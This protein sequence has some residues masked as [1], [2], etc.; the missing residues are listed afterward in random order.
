M[1]VVLG[2]LT[3]SSNVPNFPQKLHVECGVAALKY[4]VSAK[5]VVDAVA[6]C[7]SE[8]FL[9]FRDVAISNSPRVS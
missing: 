5:V 2:V 8:K 4:C 3:D 7:R 9:R 1:L 6:L